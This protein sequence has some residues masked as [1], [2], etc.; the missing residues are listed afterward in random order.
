MRNDSLSL[1]NPESGACCDIDV[2]RGENYVVTVRS[3]TA[4]EALLEQ[5]LRRPEAQAVDA[6]GGLVT[7]ISVLENILLPAIYH[8]AVPLTEVGIRI[9]EAF[10]ACGADESR[11]EALCAKFPADLAPFERRLAGFV[12]CLVMGPEILVYHRFL[13]GLTRSD[14]ALAAGLNDAF[15]A[16]VPTGTS[17]YLTLGDMPHLEPAGCR[18]FDL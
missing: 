6:F 15:R 7:N 8:R 1:V 11:A 18:S 9:V 4:L 17:V 13:E 14:M 16:R 5:A 2:G 10:A 3:A 12:R